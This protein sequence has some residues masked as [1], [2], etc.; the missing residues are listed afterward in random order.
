[1]SD[2]ANIRAFMHEVREKA[3]Q[4]TSNSHVGADVKSVIKD[5][6]QIGEN[7]ETVLQQSTGQSADSRVLKKKLDQAKQ[8]MRGNEGKLETV[9]KSVMAIVEELKI[10]GQESNGL[11]K[12][13]EAGSPEAGQVSR[14]KASTQKMAE[15][16]V[17]LTKLLS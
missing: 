9:K 1:M 10:V 12:K 2:V 7:L 8:D 13:F 5:L 3:D 4:I 11:L 15:T 6:I 16:V 14:I 17:Q